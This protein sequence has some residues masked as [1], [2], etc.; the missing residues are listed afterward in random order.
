MLIPSTNVKPACCLQSNP[1]R[2]RP[3]SSPF[4][5]Q[6]V[7]STAAL[8]FPFPTAPRPFMPV[9]KQFPPPPGSPCSKSEVGSSR[10]EGCD[11]IA[12][13][14]GCRVVSHDGYTSRCDQT[15]RTYQGEIIHCNE[16]T[17][18]LYRSRI[19]YCVSALPQPSTSP[20]LQWQR[21]QVSQEER[22]QYSGRRSNF[23]VREA[24][25]P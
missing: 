8:A 25:S 18:Y 12:A 11:V 21:C 17:V 19:Q 10:V 20:R 23:E 15:R 22:S 2:Q 9:R 1:K 7:I 16:R 6:S 13:D 3:Q 5:N 4:P 24:F 14:R